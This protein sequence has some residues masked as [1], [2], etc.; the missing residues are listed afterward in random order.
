MYSVN[1]QKCYEKLCSEYYLDNL[2]LITCWAD[3]WAG[4]FR[5]TVKDLVP[6]DCKFHLL[7]CVITEKMIQKFLLTNTENFATTF[8]L[9]FN[10]KKKTLKPSYEFQVCVSEWIHTLYLP[11][12]QGTWGSSPVVSCS[13]FKGGL[14]ARTT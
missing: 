6:G 5:G 3:F 2:S 10:S 14:S 11:E 8:S 12:C 13:H 4:W 1:L 7:I 9:S